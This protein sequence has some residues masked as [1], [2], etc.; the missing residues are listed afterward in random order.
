MKG[1]EYYADQLYSKQD[2]CTAVD[3]YQ[4]ALNMGPTD[5]LQ[6]KYNDAYLKC[7]P[8]TPKPKPTQT[9]GVELPTEVPGDVTPEPPPPQPPENNNP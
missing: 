4:T 2:F 8:P 6:S 7:Y 1:S 9:T 3:F 5:D